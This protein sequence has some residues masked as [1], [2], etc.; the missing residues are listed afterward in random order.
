MLQFKIGEPVTHARLFCGEVAC[1]WPQLPLND[2]DRTKGDL[3]KIVPLL[4]STYGYSA[5][6]ARRELDSVVSE[7]CEKLRLAS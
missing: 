7:V 1:K 2:V 5:A 4:Q 3:A 6:R